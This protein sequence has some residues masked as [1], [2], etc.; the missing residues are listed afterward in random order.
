MTPTAPSVNDVYRARLRAR[1]TADG[2][3]LTPAVRA[4]A[5]SHE[6]GASTVYDWLSGRRPVPKWL[7]RELND[8]RP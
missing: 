1:L 2:R 8:A 7:R 4:F 5:I 3:K 6:C